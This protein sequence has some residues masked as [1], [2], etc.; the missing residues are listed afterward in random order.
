MIIYDSAENIL[1]VLRK[2]KLEMNS[3]YNDGW[4]QQGFR[5]KIQKV[6]AFF[7]IKHLDEALEDLT[8]GSKVGDFEDELELYETYGGD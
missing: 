3:P 8:C 1:N 4:V 2:W 5:E 7:D 6:E